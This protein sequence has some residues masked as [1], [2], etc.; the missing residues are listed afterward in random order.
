MGKAREFVVVGMIQSTES[1]EG[2]R[3]DSPERCVPNIG[4]VDFDSSGLRLKIRD[5]LEPLQVLAENP[6][7]W[8]GAFTYTLRAARALLGPPR[9]EKQVSDHAYT[10]RRGGLAFKGAWLL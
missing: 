10:I 8:K 1:K 4:E 3:T 9:E 2:L 5:D 7:S 6:T